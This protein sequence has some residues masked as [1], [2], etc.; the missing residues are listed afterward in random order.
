MTFRNTVVTAVVDWLVV[1]VVE[2]VVVAVVLKLVDCVVGVVVAEV[3]A[4]LLAL[5]VA[6]VVWVEYAQLSNR[7]SRKS[8][9]ASPSSSAMSSHL[10]LSVTSQ[11]PL[12]SSHLKL[13]VVNIAL[14]LAAELLERVPPFPTWTFS[15]SCSKKGRKMHFVF[16]EAFLT[17][18][19]AM[20]FG[21][22]NPG[23]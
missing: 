23:S 9:I 2:A 5:L 13:S 3:V 22:G 18:M 16:V 1:A 11:F 14:T 4:L 8:L 15:I 10:S 6:V 12:F 20:K 17:A 19:S 7:P 21:Y